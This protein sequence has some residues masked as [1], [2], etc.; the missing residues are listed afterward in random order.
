MT[1]FND[2]YLQQL[3]IHRWQLRQAPEP[4][5]VQLVIVV[6]SLTH[7]AH[8]L[9][10]NML[11]AMQIS[12]TDVIIVHNISAIKNLKPQVILVLGIELAQELLGNHKSL[13]ELRHVI[14]EY[15]Q[16]SLIVSENP[17]FLL[18]HPADKKEAYQDWLFVTHN[19][20]QVGL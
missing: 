12:A 14:N 6:P 3:G 9:L 4:Q 20:K 15:N 19:L 8:V 7:S 2:Y 16:I 17:E 10:K 11:S 18:L 13:V 1:Q 5:I